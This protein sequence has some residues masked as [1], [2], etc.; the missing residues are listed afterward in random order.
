MCLYLRHNIK[1]IFYKTVDTS[2]NTIK[3]IKSR[4][5]KWAGHVARMGEENEVYRV[6]VGKPEGKRPLGRRRRRW[7]VGIRMDLG[8]IGWRCGVDSVGSE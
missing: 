6:L 1:I 7:E 8:E 4:K 3:Q 5:W 2:K